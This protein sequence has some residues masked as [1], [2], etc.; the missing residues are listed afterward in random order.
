MST[1]DAVMEQYEKGKQSA[2]GNSNKVSQ[3]DRMKKY[4]V[5]IL[6]KGSK[7]QERRIR[8]LPTADGSTPFVEVRFHETQVDGTWLKLYDPSQEGK[9]SPLNEVREAL[10]ATGKD[11]DKELARDYR[12]KTFYIV[13]VIDRDHEEDGVKFWRF[14]FSAKS[15]GIYDKIFPIFRNKGDITD[16]EKGRDLILTLSLTKS[17]NGKEYTTINSI[18]PEDASP[19]HTDPEKIKLWLEDDLIWSDVY[20]KRP[21]EY[22]EMIARGETP[23]WDSSNNR[24]ASTSTG[25]ETI[26]NTKT[27]IIDPQ[28]NEL[29]DDDLPF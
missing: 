8:I 14:K 15:E 17:G 5:A 28:E 23:K 26:G 24:W 4:F 13:K 21:L 10:L 19:L 25:E 7:G 11:S 12:S 27:P 2:S 1:I 6:P 16:V 3:E 18:I 9:R 22:L 29:P 20:S